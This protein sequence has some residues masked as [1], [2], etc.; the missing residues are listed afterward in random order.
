MRPV[1][2]LGGDVSPRPIDAREMSNNKPLEIAGIF[3]AALG[4]LREASGSPMVT[5]ALALLWTA[6]D[7]AQ[8]WALQPWRLGEDRL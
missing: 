1:K 5:L 8:G 4:P 3:L 2:C 7:R 6:E